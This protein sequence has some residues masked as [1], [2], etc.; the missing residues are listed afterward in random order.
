MLYYGDESYIAFTFVFGGS[1][2]SSS[3]FLNPDTNDRDWH[4]PRSCAMGVFFL[5]R[6]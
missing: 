2:F 1:R 6:R 5:Q 3:C 4:K